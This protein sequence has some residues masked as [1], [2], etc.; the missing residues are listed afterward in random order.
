MTTTGPQGSDDVL[1]RR[2]VRGAISRD[3]S[4][5]TG[6]EATNPRPS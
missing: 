2:L 4:D 6:L 3:L 1:V 5:L